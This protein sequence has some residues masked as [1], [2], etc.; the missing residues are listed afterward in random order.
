MGQKKR[1][2]GCFWRGGNLRGKMAWTRVYVKHVWRRGSISRHLPMNWRDS[3]WASDNRSHLGVPTAVSYAA[4]SYLWK[5]TAFFHLRNIAKLQNMLT[6]SDFWPTR[7][8]TTSCQNWRNNSRTDWKYLFCV[9]VWLSGR[10]L[11]QLRKMLWVWF[12]G[13]TY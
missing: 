11:R 8:E 9:P 4:L 6:V 5:R 3:I 13:N 12:P 10:V 2:S 1:R 7:G